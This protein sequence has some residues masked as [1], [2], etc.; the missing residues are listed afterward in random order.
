MTDVHRE[1]NKD[2]NWNKPVKSENERFVLF[3]IDRMDSAIIVESYFLSRGEIK[4][5]IKTMFG[6]FVLMLIVFILN[7]FYRIFP[8]IG[9]SKQFF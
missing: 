7:F 4:L 9:A 1:K 6:F 3:P 5:I 2:I 8:N